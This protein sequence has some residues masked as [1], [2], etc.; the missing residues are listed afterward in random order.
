MMIPTRMYVEPNQERRI[1][2]A[3]QKGK[4]CRIKVKKC[5]ATAGRCRGEMLLTPPQ[6][7]RYQKSTSGVTLPFQHKHLVK[8]MKH[9]GGFLPLMAA[10]L[11]PIIGGVAGGLIER[12]I[13]GSGIYKK[14]NNKRSPPTKKK[15]KK[16]TAAA[17]AAAGSGMYLNPYNMKSVRGSGMYLN[18]Y[19]P[20]RK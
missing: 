20:P 2:S 14:K 16:K 10:A 5:G 1:M 7:K 13:A 11:A 9:K 3:Y 4:G 15:T 18:P 17:A 19:R 6:W 8:N 12:E